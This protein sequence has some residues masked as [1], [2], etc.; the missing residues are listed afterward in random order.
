LHIKAKKEDGKCEILLDHAGYPVQ[1]KGNEIRLL[2][3]ND[4][5]I[6]TPKLNEPDEARDGPDYDSTC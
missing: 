2:I 3:Y 6:C 4:L 1:I 5:G